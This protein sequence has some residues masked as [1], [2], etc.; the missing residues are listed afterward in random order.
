MQAFH[1]DRAIYTFGTE[2]EADLQEATSKVKGKNADAQRKRITERVFAKWLN[3][4]SSTGV[5]QDPAP[6]RW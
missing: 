6:K 2:M 3:D 4:D 1:F 5:Y